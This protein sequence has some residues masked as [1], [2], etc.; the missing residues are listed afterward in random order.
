MQH[1]SL[2]NH[3]SGS[4]I[5]FPEPAVGMGV[6]KL[7]WS[8][9]NPGTIIK[10]HGSSLIEVKDDNY[11]RID[12]NGMSE[13]QEYEFTQNLDATS[14]FYKKDGKGRWRQVNQSEKGRWVYLESRGSLLI[15]HREKYH[16]F[17]F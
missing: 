14:T 12:S 11:K 1:G 4:M 9:R 6:T 10:V 3:L 7:L 15:G 8:D 2:T 17:S 5:G 13:S 16:D